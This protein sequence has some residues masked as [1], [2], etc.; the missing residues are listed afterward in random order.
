[1][2]AIGLLSLLWV[3]ACSFISDADLAARLDGDSDGVPRPTD[4]DDDDAAVS[5][6]SAW[7][8]DADGDGFG[9]GSATEACAAPAGFVHDVHDSR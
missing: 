8:G 9:A 5:G 1:M 7:Y 2:R 4:C 3:C 6:P